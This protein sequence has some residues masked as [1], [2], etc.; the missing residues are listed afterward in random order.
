MGELIPL[1]A[2]FFVIGVPVMSL[3]A[4]FVLRPMIRDLARAI[5]GD[6]AQSEASYEQRLARLEEML[7]EQGRQ[8]DQLVDAEQFRRR[9]EAG[10]V[11]ASSRIGGD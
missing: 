9:L 6:R 10:E 4:H 5:R 1:L 7:F 3:A 11:A 8:I 2:I